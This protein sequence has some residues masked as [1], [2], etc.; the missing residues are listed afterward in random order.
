[1]DNRDG[2]KSYELRLSKDMRDA[3][4][5]ADRD[6][7]EALLRVI[8]IGLA[9]GI[10]TIAGAKK[11]GEG[12]QEMQERNDRRMAEERAAYKKAVRR[13]AENEFE[14]EY[15]A[16]KDDNDELTLSPSP[17]AEQPESVDLI[18]ESTMH[19]PL[20][21]LTFDGEEE[22]EARFAEAMKEYDA[23]MDDAAG[24]K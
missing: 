12:L 14:I 19:D 11:F 16:F 1:M 15:E 10:A 13:I 17:L 5:R 21:E 22:A 23:A 6:L 3:G 20:K 2:R 18:L 9:G 7:A 8:A 4:L 24:V